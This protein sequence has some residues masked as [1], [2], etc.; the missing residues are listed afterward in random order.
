VHTAFVDEHAGDLLPATQPTAA[1]VAAAAI[2]SRD[3]NAP[4]RVDA[5]T[6]PMSDP[7]S[8]LRGWGR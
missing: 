4:Q 1:A 5:G 7:W 6:T 8:T 3:R 2:A